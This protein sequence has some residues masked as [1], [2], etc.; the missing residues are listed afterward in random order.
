MRTRQ[1]L[2][3][4][5]QLLNRHGP[6]AAVFETFLEQHR[7]NSEFVRLAKLSRTIKGAIAHFAANDGAGHDPSRLPRQSRLDLEVKK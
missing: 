4:C 1:L 2:S 6:S 5:A 3:E 7:D